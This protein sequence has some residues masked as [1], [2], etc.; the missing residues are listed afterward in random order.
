M[1]NVPKVLRAPNDQFVHHLPGN[2]KLNDDVLFEGLHEHL[3]NHKSQNCTLPMVQGEKVQFRHDSEI[4]GRHEYHNV[5]LA[6]LLDPLRS[7]DECNVYEKAAVRSMLI[8]DQSTVSFDNERCKRSELLHLS[9][10]YGF[11]EQI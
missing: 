5:V 1:P 10:C 7:V 9:M 6:Q 11:P 3:H 4:H 2:H 8:A